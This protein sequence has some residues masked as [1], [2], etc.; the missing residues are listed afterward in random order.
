[1]HKARKVRGFTLIEML[2]VLVLIGLLAGLVGPKLFGKVDSSK[3]QTA[4]TQVKMI[5]GALESMRLDIGRLP[6]TPEG[7]ALL[8]T[9]PQDEKTRAR[10]RGPYL[11]GDLPLDPWDTPYQYALTPASGGQAFALYSLGADGKLG[12]EGNDADV[13]YVPVR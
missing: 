11:D 2:V 1:M 6:S 5:K 4:Q 3:V 9:P 13:G 12:G 10:W 8:T 7:L